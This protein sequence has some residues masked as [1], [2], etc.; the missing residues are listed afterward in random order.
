[1]DIFVKDNAALDMRAAGFD[2]K[3]AC[4]IIVHGHK[5]EHPGGSLIYTWQGRTIIG[6]FANDR[7]EIF[8]FYRD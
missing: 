3:K 8:R 5:R 1:M 6:S 7:F 2:A 4:D